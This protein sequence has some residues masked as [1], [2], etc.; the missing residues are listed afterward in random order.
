MYGSAVRE[1]PHKAAPPSLRA[2]YLRHPT[3]KLP[4]T[5]FI[6]VLSALVPLCACAPDSSRET[7]RVEWD[8]FKA[9]PDYQ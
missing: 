3:R 2:A 8:M 9:A 7:A 5:R 6:R 1:G 4:Q